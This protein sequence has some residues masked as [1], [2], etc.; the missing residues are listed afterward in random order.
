MSN[1]PPTYPAVRT[2][3]MFG[4]VIAILLGLAPVV[5]VIFAIAFGFSWLWLLPA[6]VVGALLFVM[7]QSYVEVL[8]ILTD[9]LMPR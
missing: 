4:G 7:L 5:A 2:I 3:T 9:T 1:T 8:R 6:T